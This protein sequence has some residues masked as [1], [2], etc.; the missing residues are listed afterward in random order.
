MCGHFVETSIKPQYESVSDYLQHLKRNSPNSNLKR[1]LM[2]PDIECTCCGQ[3]AP[4][5]AA[6]LLKVEDTTPYTNDL[7]GDPGQTLWL[8]A[9][10]YTSGVRPKEVYFGD[11]RW[12]KQGRRIKKRAQKHPQHPW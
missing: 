3:E 5:V 12:N 2:D 8:C 6:A 1:D 4:H 7:A 10:C 9:D 11:I